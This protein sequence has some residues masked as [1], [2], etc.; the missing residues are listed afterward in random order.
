MYIIIVNSYAGKYRFQHIMTQL[1][2]QLHIPFVT[3][4][5]DQYQG[6]DMWMEIENKIKEQ[7]EG[8]TGFI[9]VGGDGTFHQTIQ[10]LLPYNLPFGL[11]PTGSG[12]DFGR[13]LKIPRNTRKA[14]ER[15][16]KQQP[17][18]YDLMEVNGQKVLSVLGIG[19]DA[20]TAIKCQK[21]RIK[22][23][24]N[25]ALLGSLAYI[26]VALKTILTFRSFHVDIEV[27]NGKVHSF[28]RTW[29]IAAGNSSYYGGGIPI[30]PT[31]DPQNEKLDL[32]IVHGL[33][34][35]QLFLV[36]PTV[37][38]KKH[39]TL[40]YV[41]TLKGEQFSIKTKETIAVQGDG[42]E[43]GKTPVQVKVLKKAI[44]IY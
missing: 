20:E 30:C 5:S 37:F 36:M 40:P 7:K 12:N 10:R 28:T 8:V 6:E 4:F 21:S 34:A 42:E 22:K 27:D 41:T 38:L 1:N 14:I 32:V 33:N 16:N 43:L 2:T 9:V 13:A 35:F 15:I 19:V 31:A 11:I 18:L 24:L 23:I 29:L 44:N 39:V 17:Q 3:Y 26:T 25:R